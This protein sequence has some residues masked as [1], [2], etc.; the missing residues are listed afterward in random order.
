[1]IAATC[2]LLLAITVALSAIYVL[3]NFLSST[4]E[5]RAEP[6]GAADEHTRRLRDL[7]S[8]LQDAKQAI[9]DVRTG[10]DELSKRHEPPV[11]RQLVDK[12]SAR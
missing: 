1:V 5:C 12:Y 6:E 3:E 2:A 10:I 4:R 11:M 7:A 9:D 8:Q